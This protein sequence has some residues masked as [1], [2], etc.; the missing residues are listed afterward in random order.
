MAESE[1]QAAADLALGQLQRAIDRAPI[2]VVSLDHAGHIVGTNDLARTLLGGGRLLGRK[3]VPLFADEVGLSKALTAGEAVPL[4]TVIIAADKPCEL[5]VVP[6][7]ENITL[8]YVADLS[9]HRALEA[10]YR[11]SQKMQAIGQLAG[12]VAHDFNNL[13]TAMLG[14]CDL[15]LDRH[16]AGDPSFADIVQIKQNANR[17]INL[18]R[19]LLAVSRQQAMRAEGLDLRDV[20]GDVSELVRRLVG[21][22]IQVQAALGDAPVA[23]VADRG[24][25]EQVII[26]LAVNARDAMPAGGTLSLGVFVRELATPLEHRLGRIEPGAY[27]V[28]EV[29]DTGTGIPGDVLDKIF[30]PFFTT[31]PAG[32][33]TGLGLATVLGIVDQLGG[34]VVVETAAAKGTRFLIYLPIATMRPQAKPEIAEPSKAAQRSLR[35]LLVED[36]RAVR[37]L[38]LRALEDAGHTVVAAADAEEALEILEDGEIEPE[39]L[40]SDVVMPGMDGPSLYRRISVE[41]PDMKVLF[42]SGYAEDDLRKDIGDLTESP[43]AGFIAKPFTLAALRSAIR[44]L[45]D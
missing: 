44:R 3:A 27:G 16:K 1:T 37:K 35:I 6:F 40:V 42:M 38:A 12:G 25:L 9:H 8:L 15:L 33:G 41:R 29:G 2:G 19:Q 21:E 31:K 30:E 20:V 43:L 5:T 34:Q 36:E 32:E 45:S 7:D 14:Y 22:R 17:A 4:E 24:Q 39:F 18:V 10:Q 13:L 28:F 26:N 11:Q 23:V